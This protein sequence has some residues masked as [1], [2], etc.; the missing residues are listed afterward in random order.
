[1]VFIF[2]LLSM[3]YSDYTVFVELR[4]SFKTF[5]YRCS[6]LQTSRYVFEIV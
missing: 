2:H 6:N 4:A 5:Y 3:G 1:M